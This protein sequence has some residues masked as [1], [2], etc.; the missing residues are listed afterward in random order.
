[1]FDLI[2]E[3]LTRLASPL[4][5]KSSAARLESLL[6]QINKHPDV[7]FVSVTTWQEIERMKNEAHK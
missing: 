1:M 3:K 2:V 5:L 7:A 6:A 4:L